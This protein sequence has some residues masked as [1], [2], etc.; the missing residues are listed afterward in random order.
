[1]TTPPLA[2]NMEMLRRVLLK[3][4]TGS[5]ES[6]ARA[7]VQVA[8]DA[9]PDKGDPRFGKDLATLSPLIASDLA[10]AG[11]SSEQPSG[12]R[13]KVHLLLYDFPVGKADLQDGHL[14]MLNLLRVPALIAR[15]FK[16]ERVIGG[17]SQT[18]PE[19]GTSTSPGNAALSSERAAVVASWLVF[20]LGQ[21]S[22]DIE[23]L[24]YG[25]AKPLIDRTGHAGGLE[26]P[27]NRN[28]IL[29][30][31]VAV[32]PDD[33]TPPKKV[34]KEPLGPKVDCPGGGSPYWS[35]DQKGEI[36][37]DITIPVLGV[38]GLGGGIAMRVFD[39]NK[40]DQNG[41][42][43][44]TKSFIAI[45]GG[46][47]ADV[48]PLAFTKEAS[49]IVDAVTKIRKIIN[50]SSLS[51]MMT[52]APWSTDLANVFGWLELKKCLTFDDFDGT[53]MLTQTVGT[54]M[55]GHAG[56]AEIAYFPLLG[57]ITAGVAYE[58]GFVFAPSAAF[59]R[60][61]WLFMEAP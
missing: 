55:A 4:L 30:Y 12:G 50:A 32:R 48:D 39:L 18:G 54:G 53:L 59:K 27:L 36:A 58:S 46:G 3:A 9:F 56:S 49:Q 5:A 16:V 20:E 31:S 26:D 22:S 10:T 13:Q 60:Q 33:D 44:A 8:S 2:G 47:V 23:A 17:A 42:K 29:T 25:S 35:V 15:G 28:V 6:I 11:F 19:T 40:L 1:M 52:V 24:S 51:G 45:G 38:I 21:K 34:Q 37:L 14:R 41:K 57:R 7:A 61:A 43:L